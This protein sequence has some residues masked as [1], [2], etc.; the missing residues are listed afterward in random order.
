MG[1]DARRKHEAA[2]RH[3]AP[4]WRERHRREQRERRDSGQ[5][6]EEE[7][8][9]LDALEAAG[10]RTE[11]F[12]LFTSAPTEATIDYERAVPVLIEWLP[13]VRDPVLKEIIVRSLTGEDSAKGEGACVLVNEFRQAPNTEEWH[14][15]KWAI[16]DALAT[17]AD[18]SLADDLLELLQ[19]GRHGSSRQ[20]LCDALARTKDDR[21]PE[22]LIALLDEPDLAGHAIS[23]LRRYGP[24]AW[25]P[26]LERARP[27]LER[28][29]GDRGV[30][31]VARRQAAAALE[32]LPS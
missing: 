10:V 9:L 32:R 26:H 21:A 25:L 24:K 6:T 28:L 8:G 31:P 17:L 15:V 11:D 18:A 23:A 7:R 1:K 5:M 4:G 20:R 12:G 16:G 3:V 29:A 22:A 13:R 2:L 30:P 14:S 27:T 19:D